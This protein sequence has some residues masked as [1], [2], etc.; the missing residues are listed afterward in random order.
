MNTFRHLLPVALALAAAA[1]TPA[2]ADTR[3]IDGSQLVATFNLDSDATIE[4]DGKLHGQIRLSADDL[5]CV[6]TTD[7]GTVTVTT[8][9]CGDSL[10]HLRIEVPYT[11]A[12]TLVQNGDGAVHVGGTTGRLVATVGGSGDLTVGRVGALVLNVTGSGD[13]TVDAASGTV[14]LNSD[15][16]GSIRI[17]ELDG[18]LQTH[19]NGSGDLVIGTIHAGA[20]D[21]TIDSS[22]DAVI[23]KGTIADLHARLSGSGDLVVAATAVNADLE[24][25][26]GGDIKIA[27]VTGNERK[28]ASGSSSIS[29]LNSDLA[30]LGIGKLA[31]VVADSD[32]SDGTTVHMGRSHDDGGGFVHFL[33]GIA[34]LVILFVIWRTVQRNGGVAQLQNRFR[35]PG[36][37][38]QPT[39]PGV[40]AVRDTIGRLEQRLARVEGYVT[41]REFDLQRKFRELDAKK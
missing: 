36:Q 35:G 31:Q 39:H 25:S 21:I 34:V 40:I 15:A 41:T 11:S 37:P 38:A 8:S 1:A 10:G 19:L 26:G 2:W 29:V 17:R 3:T 23:G 20:A 14:A 18:T 16:S 30:Q 4:P 9:G 6:Q 28:S 33:A 13:T 7:G 22:G 27:H 24:A 32:D 5:S 12:V